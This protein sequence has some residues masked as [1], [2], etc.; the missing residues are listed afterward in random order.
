MVD[1]AKIVERGDQ[2][3]REYTTRRK[4]SEKKTWKQRFGKPLLFLVFIGINVGV[5]AATAINEFG[6]SKEAAELAEI[7][8]NW[9]LLI[10]AAL[11]FVVA[12]TLDLYKYVLLLR[13]N[14]KPGTFKRGEDWKLAR[15]TVIFGRYYDNITPAAV[16]GQ[17]FQIYYLHKS[18]KLPSG[19]ATT[20]PMIGMISLQIG[21][22]I[23]ALVC[24]IAGAS[25]KMM[26]LG[27]TAWLGLLFYAFWPVMV[28]IATFFPKTTA[29]IINF[30]VKLLAKVK[31]IKNR[32]AAVKRIE[33][34]V[35]EYAASVKMILKQRGLLAKLIIIMV[36]YNI[37]IASIPFFVLTAFGGDVAYW[38]S[39]CLTVA[40]MSA[41]YF[42]PTPGNSGAAEGAFYLVFNALSTGYVFWAM[43][44]WRFFTYYIYI[45]MGPI[46]YLIIKIEKKK[47][48]DGK[49]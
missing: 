17:P 42:V 44:I 1:S 12:F 40:V 26:M 25:D 28:L 6:N 4:K 33:Y 48:K 7:R 8:I 10:P 34:E 22:I 49:V 9:W 32:D 38:P 36:I 24:F 23:L 2:K 18:G 21:F 11:C 29:K 14:T 13:K 35:G 31:I 16:G 37:L 41:V 19:L 5:I 15:R 3:I 27:V 20:L 39:L 45:I 43:L 47:H 30:V 46:T